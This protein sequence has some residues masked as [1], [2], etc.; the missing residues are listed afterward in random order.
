MLPAQLLDGYRAFRNGR[1]REEQDRFSTLAV[2]GQRPET[3]II[4]CCDSRVSPEVIF[5]A[6]PGEIFVA[7]NVANIVPPYR[8]DGEHHGTSAAL[9]FAVLALDVRHIVVLGHARCGGVRAY[10]ERRAG[11]PQSLSTGDFIGAWIALLEE[12]AGTMAAVR[13]E[14]P[15]DFAARLEIASLAGQ[16]ANLR[17][18]PFVQAREDAGA[19][20]LHACFFD[21]ATGKLAWL[22]PASGRLCPVRAEGN[23]TLPRFACTG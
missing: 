5:G 17:T 23:E 7:R 12:S 16:L 15:Q 19:L 9:E 20:S 8:P 10:A 22:D 13:D 21:I 11:N 1:L 14:N 4:G 3:M 2:E 6:R 18:F